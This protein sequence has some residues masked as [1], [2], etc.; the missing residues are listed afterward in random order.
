MPVE[1]SRA[2]RIG[3]TIQRHLSE[4]V[5]KLKDPRLAMITIHE[6]R[7]TRDLSYAKIYFTVLDGDAEENRKILQQA[8]GHLRYELGKN[9][10]LRTM[11]ELQFV[12]DTSIDYGNNLQSLIEKAVAEDA[13]KDSE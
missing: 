12:I 8:A 9:S 1:F 11:P 13:H 5:P 4:L 2:E 6:A 3:V 10:K 7:V